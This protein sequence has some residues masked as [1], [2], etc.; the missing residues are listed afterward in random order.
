MQADRQRSVE[1]RHHFARVR[2][3]RQGEGDHPVAQPRA[4]LA[5]HEARRRVAD[6]RP[7]ITARVI[8]VSSSAAKRR[9][10]RPAPFAITS[11]I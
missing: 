6:I 4:E 1:R 8:A 5:E 3:R 2:R 11:K 7:S 9:A 10:H